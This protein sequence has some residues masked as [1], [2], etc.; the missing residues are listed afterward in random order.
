[1]L[2]MGHRAAFVA[3]LACAACIE[4]STVVCDDGT[5]CPENT[6]CNLE[7]DL[8][9]SQAQLDACAE[10][11]TGDPCTFAG[12][13]GECDRGICVSATCGD[14]RIGPGEICDD[15]NLASGDGCRGDCRSLETCGNGTIDFE[16]GEECD[17]GDTT[18]ATGCAS[19]NSLDNPEATCR[20][21]CRAR[22][23]DNDVQVGEVCDGSP[24][25]GQSC[26]DY[27]FDIGVVSC[28]SIC[29]PALTECELFGWIP[30]DTG[31]PDPR[32]HGVW[33][34]DANNV[35][36]VGDGVVLRWNGTA[37]EQQTLPAAVASASF[38]GVWGRNASDVYAV[39]L[40]GAM[41]H[42]DGSGWAIGPYTGTSDLYAVTG[43]ET[44]VIA[45]GGGDNVATF[46]ESLNGGPLM[47][48]SI[49]T[50]AELHGVTLQ[51]SSVIAVG[52]NGA[53]CRRPLASIAWT[54][55]FRANAGNFMSVV[56]RGAAVFAGA[57]AAVFFASSPTTGSDFNPILNPGL[58]PA[59]SLALVDDTIVVGGSRVYALIDGGWRQLS[60]DPVPTEGLWGAALDDMW[61]V[62][63]GTRHFRGTTW[64][65]AAL[66]ALY[67]LTAVDAGP[68][69]IFA[70]GAN[71]LVR[72][73]AGV[74]TAL[75]AGANREY[76]DVSVGTDAVAALVENGDVAF[77]FTA[78][79]TAFTVRTMGAAI[80]FVDVWVRDQANRTYALSRTASESYVYWTQTVTG[81]FWAQLTPALAVGP[82]N[83]LWG[84]DDDNMFVAGSNGQIYAWNGLGWTP[85]TTN[86][87]AE[88]L[89]VGGTSPTD[90]WAVGVDG[91]IL[92]FDGTAW[93]THESG[94]LATLESVWAA[95][96]NDVFATGGD[97]LLHYDG[98]RWVPVR[99]ATTDYVIDIT[100]VGPYVIGVGR[101]GGNEVLL[102][103]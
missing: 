16:A 31:L 98:T 6:V 17:C 48:T 67:G 55:S 68:A 43:N 45:V 58:A 37:W 13:A 94:T 93:T 38:R 100:G 9:V 85:Q 34:A 82:M 49:T 70:V 1:M 60:D 44:D 39:G 50:S 28:T 95:A 78:P 77:S 87:T 63:R 76:V 35:F 12:I 73:N 4:S 97:T 8:C 69:G 19:L 42:Y 84:I 90:V 103:Y 41:V 54:C 71:T 83:A 51:G 15:G 24:P 22:C 53:F 72:F 26:L 11:A 25:Q 86:T 61:S 10:A 74:W 96:P 92:H 33:G 89:D 62:G 5:V 65:S 21:D 80:P 7:L 40:G 32:L 59:R 46:V 30:V 101:G 79:Y 102:R 36:A 64:S 52:H 88:L 66:D 23:G 18:V 47:G 57:D 56:A 27:G 14:G 2:L 29:T 99:D 81:A 75:A 91:T 20:P 3:L